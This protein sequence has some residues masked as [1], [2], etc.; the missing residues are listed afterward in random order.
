MEKKLFFYKIMASEIM[1][2]VMQIQEGGHK[3]WLEDFVIDLVAAKGRSEYTKKIIQDAESYRK[4]KSRAGKAG[5]RKR[6]LNAKSSSDQAVLNSD[7]ADTSTAQAIRSR[8]NKGL[9]TIVES[10]KETRVM[11]MDGKNINID[12]GEEVTPFG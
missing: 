5:G 2:E 12:T 4:A 6:A 10:V 11:L 1:S 7:Q 3:K 8:S 9:P